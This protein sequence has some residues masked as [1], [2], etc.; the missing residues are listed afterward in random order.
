[1]ND[2]R[3][4]VIETAWETRAE[5]TPRNAVTEV[6]Q[7]VESVIDAL[8]AGRLRVASRGAASGA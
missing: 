7:A 8:D 4:A 2:A 3:E 5:L 1:M 6:R